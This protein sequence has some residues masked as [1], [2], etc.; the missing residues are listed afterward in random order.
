MFSAITPSQ[1]L[2]ECLGSFGHRNGSRLF[3]EIEEK[4]SRYHF[5]LSG[6]ATCSYLEQE[7]NKA[8]GESLSSQQ[9]FLTDFDRYGLHLGN[10]MV[11]D[12]NIRPALSNVPLTEASQS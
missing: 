2:K 12:E 9:L 1:S 11:G 8:P 3:P 7:T 10:F 4:S 6:S 5:S